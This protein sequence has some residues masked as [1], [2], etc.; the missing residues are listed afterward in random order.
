MVNI[1]WGNTSLTRF[2]MI[3]S[4]PTIKLI[5]ENACLL[6]GTKMISHSHEAKRKRN[7]ILD[8]RLQLLP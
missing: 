8:E 5:G 1:A 2:H 4:W 6:R 7:L 3:Y